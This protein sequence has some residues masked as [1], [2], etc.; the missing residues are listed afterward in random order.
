MLPWSDQ[1]SETMVHAGPW[2]AAGLVVTAWFAVTTPPDWLRSGDAQSLGTFALAF[3]VAAVAAVAYVCAWAATPLAALLIAKGL[4]PA[5]AVAALLIGSL[6]NREV[7]AALVPS[8]GRRA[9]AFIAAAALVTT[10]VAAALAGPRVEPLPLAPRW[11]GLTAAAALAAAALWSLW[12]YGLAAWL[13]PLI[14]DPAG[15]HHHQHAETEA[16]RDGCHAPLPAAGHL[17]GSLT[18]DAELTA[19]LTAATAPA[20][21]DARDPVTAAPRTSA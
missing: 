4:P 17:D 16:C 19:P 18:I 21:D 11:L 1:L 5:L 7:L 12:R 10:L 9:L 14:A 15:H 8:L 2:L 6:T 13:E 20:T 3:I